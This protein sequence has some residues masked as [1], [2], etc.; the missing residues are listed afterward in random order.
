MGDPRKVRPRNSGSVITVNVVPRSSKI[1]I[2]AQSAG[3][4]KIRLTAPPVDGA[5]NDQLR[6]VIAEKLSISRSKIHFLS[7]ES[8]RTKQLKIDELELETITAL[9]L[10]E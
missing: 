10:K 2:A 8:S 1:S 7:G 4:F 6:K 9:L 5:A 3:Y